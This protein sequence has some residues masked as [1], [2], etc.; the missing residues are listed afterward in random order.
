MEALETVLVK[1]KELS[2]YLN[3]TEPTHPVNVIDAG[4]TNPEMGELSE[5]CDN[6]VAHLQSQIAEEFD[7]DI[8][9]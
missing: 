9:N 3:E 5:S 2:E 6:L 8:Y 1:A 7:K 4:Y